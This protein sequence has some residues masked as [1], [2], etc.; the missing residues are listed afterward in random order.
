MT[1]SF[2]QLTSIAKHKK[3]YFRC[4]RVPGSAPGKILFKCWSA[5]GK[6]FFKC[7][8]YIYNLER[9]SYNV[10]TRI[11]NWTEDFQ[12]CLLDFILTSKRIP[13]FTI[14]MVTLY[15]KIL[16]QNY[17]K[18]SGKRLWEVNRCLV[19]K[20]LAKELKVLSSSPWS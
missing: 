18:A 12:A 17:I 4:I 19:G 11:F 16:V 3:L 20:E 15:N 14:K 10:L 13:H 9:A 5:S 8:T 1:N 6:I 7:R 2:Y